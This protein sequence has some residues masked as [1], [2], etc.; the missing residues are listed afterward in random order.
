[1][2]LVTVT[3]GM[4]SKASARRQ[5]ATR[6]RAV[7]AFVVLSFGSPRPVDADTVGDALMAACPTQE[8]AARQLD[9]KATELMAIGEDGQYPL[10][11]Q[12]ALQM[13]R[14]SANARKPYARDWA[15]FFY[16]NNLFLSM[17]TNGEVLERAPLG[18][19][20]T[21]NLAAA[22]SYSDVRRAALKLRDALRTTYASAQLEVYGSP[23]PSHHV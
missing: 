7:A 6:L 19:A 13:Y 4:V 23:S 1:M 14:C 18:L 20:V 16:A 8:R 22:T 17:R 3:R 5:R 2:L 10:Y 15:R 12:E 11:R 9:H 21:N